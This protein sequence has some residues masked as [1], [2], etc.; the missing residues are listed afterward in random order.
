MMSS[1]T[2]YVDK[3]LAELE[4]DLRLSRLARAN[5]RRMRERHRREFDG[6]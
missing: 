3:F 2:P 5:W 1:A 6:P 4:E